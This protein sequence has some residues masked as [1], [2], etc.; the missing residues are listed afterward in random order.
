MNVRVNIKLCKNARG[1][2]AQSFSEN[3][4]KRFAKQ[5]ASEVYQNRA[6]FTSQVCYKKICCLFDLRSKSSALGIVP[7]NCNALSVPWNDYFFFLYV[8]IKVKFD[9]EKSI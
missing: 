1:C 5:L 7:Q 4:A 6:N 3:K 8:R 9:N 2:L